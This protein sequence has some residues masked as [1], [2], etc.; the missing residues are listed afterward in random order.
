MLFLIEESTKLRHLSAKVNFF[1][2]F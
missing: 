1:S 2:H